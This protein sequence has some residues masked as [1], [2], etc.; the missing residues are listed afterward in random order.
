MIHFFTLLFGFVPLVWG[1]N[2]L[3]KGS[4]SF[5]QRRKVPDLVIGLTII[6]FG[7]SFPELSVN[8]FFSLE[9]SN[10]LTAGNVVGSNIFNI[11][12]ILG[13]SAIVFPLSI[14]PSITW[15][16]V[17]LIFLAALVALI[18]ASDPFIDG[19][20]ALQITR[21]DGLFMIFFFIIFIAGAIK[22]LKN[23]QTQ[24]KIAIDRKN[25]SRT[26]TWLYIGMG[27]AM[28]IA[29]GQLIV[30]SAESFA[31]Y[32]GVTERIIAVIV[33]GIGTSLPELVV[34]IIAARKRNADLVVGIIVGSNIFNIFF[35]L[36]LSALIHPIAVGASISEDLLFNVFISLLLF[37]FIFTGKGR[38]VDRTEGIIFAGLYVFYLSYLIFLM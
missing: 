13:V 24:M 35:I 38:M 19:S 17:P 10:F 20:S 29:G 14:K 7:T 2:M 34:C 37:I 15:K 3:I 25:Y 4:I 1:A 31:A 27:L 6:A 11:A 8:I 22:M 26:K 33:V 36:G 32:L 9:H 23:G 21:T 16:E 18:A 28:L 30:Y 5:A 12:A